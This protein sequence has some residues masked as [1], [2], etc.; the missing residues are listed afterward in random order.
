MGNKIYQE[1]GN[2]IVITDRHR[3]NL[4]FHNVLWIVGLI[5]LFVSMVLVVHMF[6]GFEKVNYKSVFGVLYIFFWG[7]YW[8]K[9]FWPFFYELI[10]F[11][12]PLTET[13]T[14]AKKDLRLYMVND[15]Y[16][17]P[18]FY[19]F[20]LRVLFRLGNFYLITD[21]GKRLVV[22][23]DMYLNTKEGQQIEATYYKNS[24]FVTSLKVLN[25]T[26]VN[27]YNEARELAISDYIANKVLGGV[28]KFVGFLLLS[29][30]II[31]IFQK[32]P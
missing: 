14:V 11:Q 4:I 6:Q 10:T 9:N 32:L 29:G 13:F 25:V 21:T 2:L 1:N 7:I 30:L 17:S 31:T 26:A 27:D 16:N 8:S 23:V 20:K 3:F 12:K 24:K 22:N 19:K 18:L 5:F 28:A 15:I